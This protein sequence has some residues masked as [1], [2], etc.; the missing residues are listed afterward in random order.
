MV[1]FF[2]LFLL[3]LL[4]LAGIG[5]IFTFG[6]A[7]GYRP[8]IEQIQGLLTRLLEQQLPEQEWTFFLAMPIRHEATLD[9]LRQRCEQ[10]QEQYG[11]RARDGQV[12]L[13]EPGL[14]KL[15]FILQQLEQNGAR[16]F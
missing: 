8:D 16:S 13:A 3:T 1:E 12:R 9:A 7:P 10:L 5:V 11:L 15:R 2:V 14:I 6:K 4:V